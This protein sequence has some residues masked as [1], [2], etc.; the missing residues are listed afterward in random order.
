METMKIISEFDDDRDDL[1][2]NNF[3]TLQMESDAFYP[4]KIEMFHKRNMNQLFFNKPYHIISCPIV[5]R[6]KTLK[7]L[8][9]EIKL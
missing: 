4:W 8:L 3:L 7:L 9:Y 6:K 1:K 5:Q 2:Q